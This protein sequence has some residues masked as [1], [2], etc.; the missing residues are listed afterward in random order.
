MG[1]Q[2]TIFDLDGTILN[3]VD[4]LAA[5]MNIAMKECG[6]E[7]A[8]TPE[9][10]KEFFGSGVAVAVRRALYYQKGVSLEVLP[11]VGTDREI[12][13][14]E[15]STKEVGRIQDVFRQYYQEHCRIKTGEYP[16]ITAMLKALRERGI[17]TGV[18]SNKPDGA[19]QEL[20]A[21][22]FP[23]LF[24]VVLGETPQ[25]RR[26][27]APDMLLGTLK[28]MDLSPETAVY[29]G[30]TE[31]DLQTAAGLKMDCISVTW[32]FRSRAFLEKQGARIFAGDT[33]EL[34]QKITL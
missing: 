26:K 30:D 12:V 13:L 17:R 2:A 7:T 4:D 33:S 20:I 8:F 10:M 6:Y 15:I 3:T 5:S 1:Y 25:I 22:H 9:H 21:Y 23:D 19:V 31:I 32:G 29:V 24:D 27:P 18:V 16:G 11:D 34:W 28:K 14:P